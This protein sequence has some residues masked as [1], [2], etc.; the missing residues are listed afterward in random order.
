MLQSWRNQPLRRVDSPEEAG[1]HEARFP[2]FLFQL[3]PLPTKAPA[4]KPMPIDTITAMT[5]ISSDTTVAPTWLHL[6]LTYI[7][8][9]R[10]QISNS[11]PFDIHALENGRYKA[12]S[13]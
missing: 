12:V 10:L 3:F 13:R 4:T 2:V 7:I 8:K 9:S 11:I 6:V 5:K 1:G